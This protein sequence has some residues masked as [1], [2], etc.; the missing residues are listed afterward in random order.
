[1]SI[2]FHV[3]DAPYEVITERCLCTQE[4]EKEPW[5]DCSSCKGSGKGDMRLPLYPESNMANSNAF[6]LMS[7]MNITQE[8]C[9]VVDVTDIPEV[10]RNLIFAIN[11]PRT[12]ATIYE[13]E[14]LVSGRDDDYVYDRCQDLLGVFRK[15]IDVQRPV[16]WG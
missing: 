3:D 10:I 13:A 14:H 4:G 9:G 5:V 12:R 11:S 7:L 16:F 15:A 8:Y 2:T 1:M 6:A